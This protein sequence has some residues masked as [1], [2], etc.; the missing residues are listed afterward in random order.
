M[1]KNMRKAGFTLFEVI[2]VMIVI[3][4]VVGV[5]L[6]LVKTKLSNIKSYTYYYAYNTLSQI[7]REMVYNFKTTDEEYMLAYKLKHEDL[8]GKIDTINYYLLMPMAHAVNLDHELEEE[9]I[10]VDDPIG[11]IVPGPVGPIGPGPVGPV[12]PVDPVVP[13][14]PDPVVPD[15]VPG[16][17]PT[18]DPDGGLSCP[19]GYQLVNLDGTD[20]CVVT[21]VTIPR[22]GQNFCN[23]LVSYVNTSTAQFED[24]QECRG[25]SFDGNINN[26][27]SFADMRPDIVLKNGMKIYNLNGD[28]Y[29][30]LEPLQNNSNGRFYYNDD[31]EARDVDTTGYIV[32]VD[33]DGSSGPSILWQDVFPF[34]ITMA[35]K[36]IPAYRDNAGGSSPEFLSMGAYN[37]NVAEGGRS[38]NWLVKSVSFKEAACTSGYV[39]AA[40]PYCTTAPAVGTNAACTAEDSDCRIKVNRP[41]KWFN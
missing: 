35:G 21:P 17:D 11:P 16:P 41:V 6:K 8:F 10:R 2:T 33:I 23:K 1:D 29:E 9:P 37:E 27:E 15:P 30:L 24:G 39:K 26:E 34:Y 12:G 28:P 22:R 40:T 4:I 14:V 20:T 36:V 5:S 19:E 13:V 3:S 32:F 31:S 18:P 38:I 7:T 25:D